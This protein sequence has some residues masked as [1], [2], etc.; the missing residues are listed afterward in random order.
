MR[1]ALCRLFA[2]DVGLALQR[3]HFTLGKGGELCTWRSV[4][5]AANGVLQNVRFVPRSTTLASP[6]R[7]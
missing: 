2:E 5:C 3:M 6:E 7:I 4:D 1:A